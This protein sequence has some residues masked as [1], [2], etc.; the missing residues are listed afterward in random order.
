MTASRADM[1]RSKEQVLQEFVRYSVRAANGLGNIAEEEGRELIRRMVEV[2]KIT[3]EEGE[4]LISTLL[5]RMHSSKNVFESRVK[6]S[7]EK[8]IGKLSN[9]SSREMDNLNERVKELE[10]RIDRLSLRK[11][12]QAE[13]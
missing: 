1:T 3:T 13:V 7:V 5:N 10:K 6:E 9:I 2:K 4:R 11:N 8:A 12:F